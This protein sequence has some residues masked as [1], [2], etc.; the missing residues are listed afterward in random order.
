M[1]QIQGYWDTSIENTDRTDTSKYWDTRIKNTDRT[2]T[3]LLGYKHKNTDGQKHGVR[4]TTKSSF[5]EK[6]PEG[7][8]D[9]NF[10]PEVCGY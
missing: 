4:N 10:L 9:R 7:Q 5:H 3:R 1:G 2:D 8:T 6:C